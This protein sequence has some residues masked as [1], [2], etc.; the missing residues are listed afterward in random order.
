MSI[1]CRPTYGSLTVLS[2]SLARARTPRVFLEQ[3][4]LHASRQRTTQYRLGIFLG[5]WFLDHDGLVSNGLSTQVPC[6]L[7][8]AVGVE[9]PAHEW[10]NSP[11][12]AERDQCDADVLRRRR[13]SDEIELVVDHPVDPEPMLWFRG[14]LVARE[15][16][17]V[18]REI[19]ECER[20]LPVS[21]G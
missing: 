16:L 2:A 19:D 1:S 18:S 12:P 21:V 5:F 6:Y 14:D 9:D 15:T 3:N 4:V 17:V 7:V 20:A 11:F 10:S 13:G 8:R